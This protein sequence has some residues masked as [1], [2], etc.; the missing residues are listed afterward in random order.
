MVVGYEEGTEGGRGDHTNALFV[1]LC[2]YKY[3]CKTKLC[4]CCSSLSS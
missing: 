2:R 1:D 4:R 3:Y